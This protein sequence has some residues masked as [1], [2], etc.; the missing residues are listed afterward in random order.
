[1]IP[2]IEQYLNKYELMPAY[3]YVETY[4]TAKDVPYHNWYHTL[5]VFKHCMLMGDAAALLR[6]DM[7]RLGLAA[8]FHDFNHL[9]IGAPDDEN[10]DCALVGF[11]D[12]SRVSQYYKIDNPE[13]VKDLIRITQ[14]PFVEDPRNV[15]EQIIRDADLLQFTE[16]NWLE[17]LLGLRAEIAKNSS[18]FEFVDGCIKFYSSIVVHRPGNA[19]KIKKVTHR[20]NAFKLF[21]APNV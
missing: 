3:L 5:C 2:G 6:A 15:S 4:N 16:P 1:M 17:Q 11:D 9:A 20:L 18:I 7:T 12:F 19:D 14:Y 13:R 21:L 8:L 10:I